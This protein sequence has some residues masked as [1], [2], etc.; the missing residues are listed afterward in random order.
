M[1]VFPIIAMAWSQAGRG[2]ER[3]FH[4]LVP[5]GDGPGFVRRFWVV[6]PDGRGLGFVRQFRVVA[7]RRRLVLRLHGC[8]RRL[9]LFVD[10]DRG[11]RFRRRVRLR[12]KI[13]SRRRIDLDFRF[14]RFGRD[15]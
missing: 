1:E 7:D 15:R 13:D 11:D 14:Q 4:A 9:S 8:V 3:P 10:H 6:L 12:D 2:L 5:A